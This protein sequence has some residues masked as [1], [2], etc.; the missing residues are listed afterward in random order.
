MTLLEIRTEF[1]RQTGRFDLVIDPPGDMDDNGANFFINAGQKYLDLIAD[2][3]AT[4][5]IVE[6]PLA[7]G[8]FQISV[9]GFRV[10]QEVRVRDSN[11]TEWTLEPMRLPDLHDEYG[12]EGGFAAG[13]RDAPAVFAPVPVRS[14]TPTVPTET[15]RGIIVQPAP[16]S[17]MTLLLGGMVWSPT[18]TADADISFWS[19]LHPDLLVQ[20]A[21][22]KMEQFY[23]NTQ[24][25]ND[26]QAALREMITLLNHDETRSHIVLADHMI[27]SW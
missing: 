25:A 13:D 21:M 2:I 3:A 24:G 8:E 19:E 12:V 23:R 10:I 7:A 11:N 26:H 9:P 1:V 15:Y 27:D 14:S 22:Y 5:Q 20:A 4:A 18:L 17:D 16:E 6:V